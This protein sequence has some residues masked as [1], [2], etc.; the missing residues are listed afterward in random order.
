MK[1]RGKSPASE[2]I[3]RVKFSILGLYE[4]KN[5][6]AKTGSGY[7]DYL[8]GSYFLHSDADSAVVPVRYFDTQHDGNYYFQDVPSSENAELDATD[9]VAAFYKPYEKG[10]VVFQRGGNSL[11]LHNHLPINFS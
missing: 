7:Y 1:I 3:S 10:L 4:G 6:S 2:P 5:Y 11:S 9:A 8:L